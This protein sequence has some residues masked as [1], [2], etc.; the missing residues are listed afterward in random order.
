MPKSNN[1][2]TILQSAFEADLELK[3]ACISDSKNKINNN[4]SGRAF[5]KYPLLIEKS[6][7]KLLI[8]RFNQLIDMPSRRLVREFE[9]E[10]INIACEELLDNKGKLKNQ[11]IELLEWQELTAKIDNYRAVCGFVG[12]VTSCIAKEFSASTENDMH[13]FSATVSYI[14]KNYNKWI[15]EVM[16]EKNIKYNPKYDTDEIKIEDILLFPINRPGFSICLCL[17]GLFGAAAYGGYELFKAIKEDNATLER[18][19]KPSL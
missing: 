17:G 8:K 7:F 19:D 18:L 4:L 6:Q 1:L 13:K 14:N 3:A 2:I 9:K 12:V 15:L 16:D 10:I 11:L 5:D